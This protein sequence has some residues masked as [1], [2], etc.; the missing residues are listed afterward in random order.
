MGP[1]SSDVGAWRG[2]QAVMVRRASWQRRTE[3]A[4]GRMGEDQGCENREGKAPR[5]EWYGGDG[6]S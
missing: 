4:P 6:W 2:A 1:G 5:R 3:A